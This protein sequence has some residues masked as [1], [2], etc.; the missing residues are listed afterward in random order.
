[1]RRTISRFLM[2]LG[3]ALQPKDGREVCGQCG[4]LVRVK[5]DGHLY[6]HLEGSSGMR[7]LGTINYMEGK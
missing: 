5:K 7:C 2:R 1:M 3:I 4:K 6:G